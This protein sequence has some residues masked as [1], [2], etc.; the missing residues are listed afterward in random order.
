MKNTINHSP[1]LALRKICV[2]ARRSDFYDDEAI[3]LKDCPPS[4]VWLRRGLVE[5]ERENISAKTDFAPLRCARN[6]TYKVSFI[7][8]LPI[9]KKSALTRSVYHFFR[10]FAI[11]Q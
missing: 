9:P 10:S 1:I 4:P 2:I 7:S 6:D 11:L 5:A 3:S 8:P